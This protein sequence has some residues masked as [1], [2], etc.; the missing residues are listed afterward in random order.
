MAKTIL[1]ADTD[2][3]EFQ[4]LLNLA[5][6]QPGVPGNVDIKFSTA[7]INSTIHYS[8]LIIYRT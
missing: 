7:V 3:R 2:R 1:I 8:A 6:V 4:R 5:L